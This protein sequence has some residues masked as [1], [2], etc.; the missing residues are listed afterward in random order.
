MRCDVHGMID[1]M[2]FGRETELDEIADLLDEWSLV[3][4]V[5]PGG[6]GK[7]T[8]AR[9]VATAGGRFDFVDLAPA[10]PDAVNEVV[11]GSLGYASFSDLLASDHDRLIVLDNC[12]HIVDEMADLVEAVL[13]TG[14]ARVLA[15]SREPLGAAGERVYRLKPM[16]V[17]GHPSRA[18]LMLEHL[19]RSRGH[20]DDMDIAEL[21]ALAAQLDGLPLALE[22]AASRAA[23]MSPKEIQT[24]LRDRLDLLSRRRTRGP[25]RHHSLNAAIS[26]SHDLLDEMDRKALLRLA[27]F[28]GRFNVACAAA[29]IDLDDAAAIE[30][31]GVLVDRS[32]LTTSVTADQ[33]WYRLYDTVRLFCRDRLDEG[34]ARAAIERVVDRV[35]GLATE[36]AF[37]QETGHRIEVQEAVEALYPIW[38]EA[39]KWCLANAET[40]DAAFQ[41]IAPLWWMEDVGYQQEISDLIEEVLQRWPGPLDE[42]RATAMAVQAELLRVAHR[43]EQAWEKASTLLGQLDHGHGVAQAARVAGMI[44]RGQGRYSEAKEVLAR[45][46]AEAE[47]I[48]FPALASEIQMHLALCEA[49]EGNV[50]AATARL[51]HA[52]AGEDVAGLTVPWLNVMLTFVQLASDPSAASAILL[53]LDGGHAG[54]LDPWS[55]GSV[56]EQ[57]GSLHAM[58]GEVA[59]A[60][61]RYLEALAVFD[62]HHIL[63]G[64]V[65]VCRGAAAL[66]ARVGTTDWEHRTLATASEL[67]GTPTTGPFENEV[68]V[69]IAGHPRPKGEGDG[70]SISRI[71]SQLE[72]LASQ[73]HTPSDDQTAAARFSNQGDSWLVGFGGV[74]AHIRDSKGMGDLAKLLASPGVEIGALDLMGSQVAAGGTGEILDSQARSAYRSR[75]RELSEEIEDAD[76]I[77]ATDTAERLRGEMEAI[78][79]QLSSAYGLGGRA[80]TTGDPAE[81]A[82]SAVTWR[83]RSAIKRIGE[84]NRPAGDHLDRFVSTGRFCVYEPPGTVDWE[85]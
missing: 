69:A 75:L 50:A 42:P 32:M 24:H 49:R 74:E 18:G 26:W 83:I 15:T 78:A 39:I 76:S 19:I 85:I 47:A 40:P 38:R 23:T 43:S 12:E 36:L 10:T 66:F 44:L 14:P 48:G 13:T 73:G 72:R 46:V 82:R 81:K 56:K 53:D 1:G 17:E 68:Y 21:D 80:R 52:L 34:E 71:R 16:P 58:K 8:L 79:A 3:T 11:A 63:P 45:G 60:A 59:E 7:T 84:A 37:P 22:L 27:V 54:P 62:E 65:V 55:K 33:T 28:D 77:G 64:I 57:L 30:T 2:I 31:L 20:G 35:T 61:R 29:A 9:A 4:I 6:V 41:M 51:R 5:G 67:F 25:E 70:V